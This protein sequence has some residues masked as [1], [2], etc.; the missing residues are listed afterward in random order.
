MKCPK[1]HYTIPAALVTSEHQRIIASRP[2]PGRIG[3]VPAN[4]KLVECPD[5]RAMLTSSTFRRR[6]KC[7]H[8][9]RKENVKP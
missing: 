4:R 7:P 8:T 5:C 6:R 1:C 2:R 3:I 9:G